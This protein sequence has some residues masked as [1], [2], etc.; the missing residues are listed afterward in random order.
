PAVDRPRRA[1]VSSFGISGTNAHVILEA[2]EVEPAPETVPVVL[3]SVPWLVSARSAEALAGQASRLADHLRVRRDVSP[4]EV[5]WSLVTT[6]A[7]LEHRAA[8]IGVD[9]NALLAGL[10]AVAQGESASGVVTGEVLSGRRAVLFT[11]QGAQRVGMG[12][13]LYEAFPVFADAF[14]RVC[15]LF[16]G[17]L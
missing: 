17:R 5:G 12:R 4:A 11:G 2:P 14:D 3:P 15:G 7:A 9:R 8:V 16:E 13:G 6:R 10:S 1:A